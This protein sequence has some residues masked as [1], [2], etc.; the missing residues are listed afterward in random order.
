MN[1]YNQVALVEGPDG[2][3]YIAE[4]HP[5]SYCIIENEGIGWWLGPFEKFGLFDDRE[6]PKGPLPSLKGYK[7]LALPPK[8]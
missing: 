1:I 2:R 3:H 4:W 8:Q 7:I 5:N 6:C